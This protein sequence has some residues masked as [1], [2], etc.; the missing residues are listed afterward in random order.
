MGSCSDEVTN[1][2]FFAYLDAVPADGYPKKIDVRGRNYLV[3]AKDFSYTGKITKKERRMLSVEI[4]DEAMESKQAGIL[5]V[6]SDKCGFHSPPNPNFNMRPELFSTQEGAYFMREM[7]DVLH[8]FNFA[9]I[10]EEIFGEDV[11]YNPI[12]KT[13]DK[14]KYGLL[15]D[16]FIG[17]GFTFSF[18]KARGKGQVTLTRGHLNA[19]E[20]KCFSHIKREVSKVRPLQLWHETLTTKNAKVY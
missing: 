7:L 13:Y 20:K 10:V 3:I 5:L 17:F 12:S 6:K 11:G 8:K 2:E 15:R 18:N 16:F 4:W 1:E 14:E 9:F 19:E